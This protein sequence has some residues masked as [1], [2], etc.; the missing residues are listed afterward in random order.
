MAAPFS[1]PLDFVA[2]L[3]FRHPL[4]HHDNI[5]ERYMY[6]ASFQDTDDA[7]SENREQRANAKQQAE[8]A[9]VV[10]QP[11]SFGILGSTA[12]QKR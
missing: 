2:F 7:R 10:L 6:Q 1:L 4:T 11:A 12:N 3:D 8:V 5:Y 9:L